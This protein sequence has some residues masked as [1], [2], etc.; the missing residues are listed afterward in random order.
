MGYHLAIVNN[1]FILIYINMIGI[2]TNNTNIYLST[3][4]RAKALQYTYTQYIQYIQYM[5]DIASVEKNVL[6]HY[7]YCHI[8]TVSL[9]SWVERKTI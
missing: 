1:G 5:V 4:S 9:A 3:R 2:S 6:F 7:I 8:M